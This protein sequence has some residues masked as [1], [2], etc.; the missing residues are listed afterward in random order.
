MLYLGRDAG[1]CSALPHILFAAT[2]LH[3]GKGINHRNSVLSFPCEH[4]MNNI[5][6]FEIAIA[7]I[8]KEKENVRV[9]LILTMLHLSPHKGF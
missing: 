7:C 9:L 2:V 4:C 8:G 5:L 1:T 3:Q 6:M